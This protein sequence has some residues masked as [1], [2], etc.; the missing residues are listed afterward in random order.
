MTMFE[1]I[2]A[3]NAMKRAELRLQE[4]CDRLENLL[5]DG[6]ASVEVETA[7]ME[8]LHMQHLLRRTT[9]LTNAEIERCQQ[10]YNVEAWRL[11]QW[12]R[13]RSK[14]DFEA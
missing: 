1:L 12:C 10:R 3:W 2:K 14:K 7:A 11:R 9:V 6:A 8:A 5:K 4:A 13:E